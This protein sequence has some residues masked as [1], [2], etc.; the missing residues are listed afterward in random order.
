MVLHTQSGGRDANVAD[1]NVPMAATIWLSSRLLL[2]D[3]RAKSAPANV[4]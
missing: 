3:L 2:L 4:S 1:N